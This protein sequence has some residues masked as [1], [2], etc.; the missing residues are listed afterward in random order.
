MRD[1]AGGFWRQLI[2]KLNPVLGGWEN[3]F[4][5]VNADGKLVQHRLAQRNGSMEEGCAH[6][7]WKSGPLNI[8][9]SSVKYPAQATPRRSS[10]IRVQENCMHSDFQKALERLS[11]PIVIVTD[12][13]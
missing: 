12:A 1:M 13:V 9:R 10:F 5:T 11:A 2:A 6:R 7:V 3:Y 8:S 4:R